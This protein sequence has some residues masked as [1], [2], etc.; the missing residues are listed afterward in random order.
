[1]NM[2]RIILVIL[3]V[4]LL[5][6]QPIMAAEPNT[7]NIIDRAKKEWQEFKEAISCLRKNGFTKCSRAQ[8]ARII[9]AGIALAAASATA[10]YV[11][12]HQ[13]P[14]TLAQQARLNGELPPAIVAGDI[15][16]VNSL[17][18]EGAAVNTSI[19]GY[20]PLHVAVTHDKL[21]VVQSLLSKG[22]RV[23]AR[24]SEHKTA[25]DLAKGSIR[26]YLEK[27][28]DAKTDDQL[29]AEGK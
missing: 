13:R 5:A 25:L 14:L 17:I 15:T 23:N 8:K 9:T 16:R 4:S 29:R 2:N 27:H 18:K 12:V 26:K 3:A 20:T 7:S 11:I 1:M 22:A 6:T 10:A 21:D 19:G 28:T 24:T